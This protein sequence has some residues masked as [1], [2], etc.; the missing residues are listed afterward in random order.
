MKSIDLDVKTKDEARSFIGECEDVFGQEID[1]AIKSLVSSKDTKIVTLSGP[2]CSGK[3]TTAR[4]LT[5]HIETK[6]RRAV[7][8][9]IDDFFIDRNNR[10]VVN[11]EAPDY[12]TVKAIDIDYFARFTERLLNG[13]SVLVP[14]Y[15]FIKTARTGYNEYIPNEN[16]IYVFEGIQAVYPEISSLLGRHESLFIC[17]NRGI[18]YHES[19]IDKNDIRLLRR[20]VRDH[21]FRGANAEFTLHL[22]DGV[23]AN[24]EEN[25]FP[26]AKSC[27]VYIDSCL[28]YEPFILNKHAIPLLDTVPK[29]SRYYAAAEEL[30]EKISAFKNDN[31]EDC[32]IPNN[33]VFR[34]FIGSL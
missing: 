1:D 24:E 25:I 23:R 8:M 13:E 14:T 10:N 15:D 29:D 5:E 6:G 11:D 19:F 30:K 21:R 9:S 32:M 12:D 7:V 16:D 4:K 18:R 26:N 22:W 20:I 31:F 33:S 17:V 27:S 2:T 3:T 34:E 28:A